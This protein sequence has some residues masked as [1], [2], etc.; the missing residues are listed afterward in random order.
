MSLLLA[1]ACAV[2]T[3]A[4]I[5]LPRLLEELTDRGAVARFPDPPFRAAMS[6][7]RDPHADSDAGHED[8]TARAP[9]GS[10]RVL[11][12]AVGPGA[13]TRIGSGNPRGRLRVFV[14]DAVPEAAEVG[15]RDD[16]RPE[17]AALDVDMRAFLSGTGPVAPPLASGCGLGAC[18]YLPIP[19]AR[20]IL[21]TAEDAGEFEY[22]V[23][24]RQYAAGTAVTAFARGD[25]ERH[26]TPIAR[27][28]EI[29]SSPR[30]PLGED[31]YTYHLSRQ[32]PEGELLASG[33]LARGSRAVSELRLRIDAA[34]RARALRTCVLRL[35]FDGEPTVAVPLGA[36]FGVPDELRPIQS[37]FL[38]V[39]ESGELVA[40]FVMP[41]RESFELR[42]DNAG[43]PELHLSGIVRTIPWSWD[44]RSLHF[45]ALWRATGPLPTRPIRLLPQ[46]RVLGRGILVGDLLA[47][48]NP[49]EAWWGE[50]G[51]VI[52]VDGAGVPS[53]RG[54]S[55]AGVCGGSAPDSTPFQVKFQAQF[56][57]PLHGRT[58]CDGPAS[59]GRTD[60][61]R[62][63]VLDAIPFERELDD[64][65]ENRHR[66]DTTIERAACVVYYAR[67]GAKDDAP[68]V[69]RDPSDSLPKLPFRRVDGAVELESAALV[70]QSEGVATERRTARDVEL[71]G[72]LQLCLLARAEPDFVEFEIPSRTGRR[73]LSLLAMRSTGQGLLRISIDG[74]AAALDL[75]A[76]DS[77][78]GA[79]AIRSIPLGEHEV[80]PTFRLRVDFASASIAPSDAPVWFGL[81]AIVVR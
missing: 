48:A 47:V 81:D 13:I 14:D 76:P 31:T 3:P 20:R 12:D 72:G 65:Q 8:G 26:A 64:A 67:P 50:G 40:R 19:F 36:F 5:D 37:W 7:S 60:L 61:Y 51:E 58:R 80:G 38:S 62:F 63:R 16:P 22:E 78:S 33:A 27:A 59:F 46:A 73:S 18:S 43:D 24:W 2:Q 9:G 10:P 21:V 1:L 25:L 4:P 11:L 54:T 57:A 53:H 77:V 74:R 17:Q 30:H 79:L 35:R 41:Y 29:W 69:P 23:E 75:T 28:N 34:D 32:A 45:H 49:V 39:T 66:V 15:P 6:S 56:Q 52:A 42:V 44:E 71:S 68:P 70:A 55:S